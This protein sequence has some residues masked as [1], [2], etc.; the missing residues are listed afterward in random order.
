L[1][2]EVRTH[3]SPKTDVPIPRDAQGADDEQQKQR[4]IERSG[5]L[6]SHHLGRLGAIDN[7]DDVHQRL[8]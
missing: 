6:P 5:G 8:G 4:T 2:N 3:L 7:A 1:Y